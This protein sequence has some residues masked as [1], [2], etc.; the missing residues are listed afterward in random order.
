MPILQEDMA[1]QKSNIEFRVGVIVLCAIV[2]VAGSLYWLQG[3]K[4]EQNAQIVTVRF[5]DVGA[6]AIG[7]D[8]TVSGVRKGKVRR[9]VLTDRGVEVDLLLYK[10]VILR[11]DASF[12]IRN[13]G[14]MGERFIAISPGKSAELFDLT[15]PVE[16]EYDTGIPEVMGLL[17]DM[18]VE[19]RSVVASM[20]QT[21]ASD[22]SL[23]SFNRTVANL[24]AVSVSMRGYLDRNDQKV[25]QSVANFLSAS[26]RLNQM[27]K[28]TAGPLEST[29]ERVD[30]MSVRIDSIT[31]RLDSV[32]M[33]ATRFADQLENGDGSLQLLLHD[34]S[35]YDD[36][37]R[38]SASIDE[39]VT[40][41]RSNPKKYLH[42]TVEVF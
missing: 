2:L 11:S 20:K 31:A 32:S 17:G 10:D 12:A 6:L 9:L 21:V 41:I 38:T 8:V 3:Y 35:L 19:L 13:M 1:I 5:D 16:G 24:E 29:V 40:D 36:L 23:A 4:L 25:D 26:E 22:S 42:V 33:A 28:K 15:K 39:L 30:R 14:V 34:R 18:I 37:R 7:D 27:M